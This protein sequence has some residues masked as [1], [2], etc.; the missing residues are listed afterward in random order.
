MGEASLLLI[1]IGWVLITLITVIRKRSLR[2]NKRIW[3]WGGVIVGGVVLSLLEGGALSDI[4]A[5]SISP[6]AKS[7]QTVGFAI[8]WPPAIVSSSLG[9]LPLLNW[10]TLIMALLEIGP[11]I[12]VLPLIIYYGIRVYRS[13]RLVEAL[14]IAGFLLTFRIHL[15]QLR[16]LDR[17]AEYIQAVFIPDPGYC[18]LCLPS[19]AMAGNEK[20]LG[21]HPI[22]IVELDLGH[23][24]SGVIRGT[25]PISANVGGVDLSQ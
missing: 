11:V 20:I 9:V 5:K 10:R 17:S 16:G 23:R 6:V 2:I 8:H 3:I 22:W 19:L 24:R 1:L 7:Y 18:I 21:H 14:L 12:F 13:N 15:G 4:L 25:T